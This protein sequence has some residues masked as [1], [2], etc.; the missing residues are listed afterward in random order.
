MKIFEIRGQEEQNMLVSCVKEMGGNET[1]TTGGKTFNL[2]NTKAYMSA[3][4]R[5][6]AG[7]LAFAHD[8]ETD[9]CQIIAFY[10]RFRNHGLGSELLDAMIQKAIQLE[11]ARLNVFLTND[12][13]RALRFFQRRGFQLSELRLDTID[14]ARERDPKIPLYG[15]DAIEVRHELGLEMVLRF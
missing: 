6:V 5:S 13:T 7:I 9:E 10:S 14:E 8:F 3:E 15:E 1:I 4:R 12:Q 2:H 11:C